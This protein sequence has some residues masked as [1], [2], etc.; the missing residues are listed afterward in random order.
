MFIYHATHIRVSSTAQGISYKTMKARSTA[1]AALALTLSLLLSTWPIRSQTEAHL[2]T[3]VQ[4]SASTTTSS[5][6]A[7][8]DLQAKRKNPYQQVDSCFR[9]IP[10]SRSNPRGNK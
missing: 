2:L 9:R 1:M 6:Q 4:D 5:S 8:K 7:L 3:E 10:P